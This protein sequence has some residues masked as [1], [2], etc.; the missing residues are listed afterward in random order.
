MNFDKW[1][2]WCSVIEIALDGAAVVLIFIF[3]EI[4]VS[5]CPSVHTYHSTRV[6]GYTLQSHVCAL[7]Q[8]KHVVTSD[9]CVIQ[10]LDQISANYQPSAANLCWNNY[11][12]ADLRSAFTQ[13]LHMKQNHGS[14]KR[15][16]SLEWKQKSWEKTI[17]PQ[18]QP[19]F[20]LPAVTVFL[21]EFL[22]I[23][24]H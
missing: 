9:S 4:C 23:S 6:T 18:Q 22:L 7:L 1:G 19:L 12:T 15:K 3:S 10:D 21:L 14:T 24:L 17:W 8:H 5:S 11:N 2:F 16:E 20:P 13:S